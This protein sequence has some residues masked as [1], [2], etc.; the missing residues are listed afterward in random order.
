MFWILVWKLSAEF[1]LR[2]LF[3]ASNELHSS[4]QYRS[5]WRRVNKNSL[6]SEVLLCLL[7]QKR[8]IV[9]FE[10]SF[11]IYSSFLF[12]FETCEWAKNTFENLERLA[13]KISWFGCRTYTMAIFG[14]Q[15]LLFYWWALKIPDLKCFISYLHAGFY[16]TICRVDVVWWWKYSFLKYHQCKTCSKIAKYPVH[17]QFSESVPKLIFLSCFWGVSCILHCLKSLVR[18]S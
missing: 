16:F 10:N 14:D 18:F 5:I 2:F 3:R 9:I 11:H 6:L 1:L 12:H 8:R 4:H 13:Y 15:K 7:I 17:N